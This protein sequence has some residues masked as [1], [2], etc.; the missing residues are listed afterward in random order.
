METVLGHR[1]NALSV[2]SQW[3]LSSF[4]IRKALE[5]STI[6]ARFWKADS[7]SCTEALELVA[8]DAIF[9]LAGASLVKFVS[10]SLV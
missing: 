9:F 1:R 5:L 10:L 2:H 4:S 8:A 6:T 7:Q 3:L